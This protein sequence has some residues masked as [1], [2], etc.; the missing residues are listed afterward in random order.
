MLFVFCLFCITPPHGQPHAFFGGFLEEG[1]SVLLKELSMTDDSPRK[2]AYG[3]H[4][5]LMWQK[6]L[7]VS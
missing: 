4:N 7:T 2:S 3:A 6:R 1:C 5:I